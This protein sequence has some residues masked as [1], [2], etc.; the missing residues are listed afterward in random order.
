VNEE[1][2]MVNDSNKET[3]ERRWLA[4]YVKMHHEKKALCELALA[5]RA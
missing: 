4:A 3:G 5:G 1:K 2:I